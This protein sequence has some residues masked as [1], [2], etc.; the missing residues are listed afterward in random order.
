MKVELKEAV[1]YSFLV[2]NQLVSINQWLGKRI[3]FSF[4][5]KMQCIQ[6]QRNI[7]KTFQQGFCFPCYKELLECNLCVIHPEKC[8]FYEGRC[9]HDHW[10]HAQCGQPHVV[11]LAQSSAVKIG[12][13]RET[14]VPS[15]W[16]DQGAVHGLP[17][18]RTT[19]RYLAGQLEVAF[20]KYIQDKTNWRAILKKSDELVDL[21][22]S[23]Q[24]L[25]QQAAPAIQDLIEKYP[26]DIAWTDEAKATPIN[27]P[28][29][30]YP[31]KIKTYDL[32][33]TPEFSDRL[34][35]VKGQYWMFEQGVIN[36]RKY[37]GYHV[38]LQSE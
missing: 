19:N 7:S 2:E 11:Y 33:K 23:L 12:I 34:L 25:K 28:V 26:Q 5:G 10:A 9:T 13:T 32:E 31:E 15:R 20:K 27:Y 17:I 4:L 24:N 14:Y 21:H 3:K 36:I 1:E 30:Q 18:L 38:A 8:A 29:L 22:Q 6:C 37:S 35:G 16:I